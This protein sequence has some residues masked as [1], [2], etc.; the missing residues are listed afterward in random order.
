MT[1]THPAGSPAIVAIAAKDAIPPPGIPGVPTD[2]NTFAR[3]IT[4]I[5]EILISIPHAFAKNMIIND[6]KIDTESIFTVA[7][8]GTTILLTLLKTPSSSSTH[9]LLIGIV[10][11]HEHDPNAL[12]AAGVN[13][14]VRK[15]PV[16]TL[17]SNPVKMA[18]VMY[19]FYHS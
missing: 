19:F 11:E 18:G 14:P 3:R 10:A 9:C 1:A 5:S 16:K 2:H 4:T 12:R 13:L 8:S 6:I 17:K 15:I 7:P